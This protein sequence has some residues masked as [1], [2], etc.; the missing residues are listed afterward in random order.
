[1]AL[2]NRELEEALAQEKRLD[3]SQLR[4]ENPL[5]L[6]AEFAALIRATRNGNVKECQE[7]VNKGVNINGRDK[8]DYT[9]LIL[10]SMLQHPREAC[11]VSCLPLFP[12]K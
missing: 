4:D 1:M 7:I 5:D 10:V 6:S 9:P 3:M 8:Y 11:R 2:K 12:F